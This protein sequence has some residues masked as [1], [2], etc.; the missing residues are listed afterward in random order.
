MTTPKLGRPPKTPDLGLGMPKVSQAFNKMVDDY[1]EHGPVIIEQPKVPGRPPKKHDDWTQK[2][3]DSMCSKPTLTRHAE[4]SLKQRA[5]EYSQLFGKRID[6]RT[7][8]A[9]Y[10]G[11]GISLQHTRT[12]RGDPYPK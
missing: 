8:R 11:K 6:E 12:R 7:L 10:Q 3:I 2:E 4:K 1:I 5:A 9:L